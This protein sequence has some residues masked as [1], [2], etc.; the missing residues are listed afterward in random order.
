MAIGGPWSPSLDGADPANDPS[1]LIKTAIREEPAFY[2]QFSPWLLLF[3][4]FTIT[5]PIY[6]DVKR[7]WWAT[8]SSGDGS[9]GQF[10]ICSAA[11]AHFSY[12][13]RIFFLTHILFL[14]GS[15]TLF[16]P[17]S[18]EQNLSFYQITNFFFG[19]GRGKIYSGKL[20]KGCLTYINR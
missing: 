8:N 16:T 1:V 5:G 4:A 11:G 6:I 14:S 10:Q 13:L 3:S 7:P 18:Q 2:L 9:L 19:G 17:F 20:G 15:S 12:F